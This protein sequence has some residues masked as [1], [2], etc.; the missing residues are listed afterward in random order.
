MTID[1][2]YENFMLTH[3]SSKTNLVVVLATIVY[4]GV[5]FNSSS[6]ATS[7][8]T[9]AASYL[10]K[11]LLIAVVVGLVVIWAFRRAC[12]EG[13]AKIRSW[14][15]RVR[16]LQALCP[17][18]MSIALCLELWR[19]VLNG[20]CQ[21]P[22]TPPLLTGGLKAFPLM[23]FF[24]LRDTSFVAVI[25]SW[26]MCL[27]MMLV[28][29]VQTRE[30]FAVSD[31]L[32]FVLASG[33]IFWDSYRHN[34]SVHKLIA[35]FHAAL[36]ENEKLAVEAQALELRAMIG[37]VAHDLKTVSFDMTA[38]LFISYVVHSHTIIALCHSP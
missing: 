8:L 29:A 7:P 26:L 28:L 35:K 32:P 34:R 6:S 33:L 17:I 36:C 30:P 5:I 13:D 11:G 10:T 9:M 12:R 4:V 37:N 2:Q 24:M 27:A 23:V 19:E 20:S 31:L 16:Q 21:D 38:K 25:V 15:G 14:S 18:M 3:Y 1:E 22:L